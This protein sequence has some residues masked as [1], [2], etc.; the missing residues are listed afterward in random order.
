MR[1][2]V[3]EVR[4]EYGLFRKPYAAMSPVSFPFPPPPAVLGMLGAV[5]GYDKTDSARRL[6]WERVRV[7]VRLLAP[8]ATYR[9]AVNLLE[10]E[11]AG[12]DKD[13]TRFFRKADGRLVRIQIPCEFLRRPAYRI[14][15]AGLPEAAR[16]ELEAL[17][18][19]GRSAYTV[20][21]GLAQCL[22]E[23]RW[24]GAR[25]A[26][27]RA[28]DRFSCPGVVPVAPALS[29]DYGRGRR[30]Q[31]LRVPVAMDPERIVHRYQ[32]VVLAEDGEPLTGHGGAGHIYEVGDETV[33]F[34]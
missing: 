17:L 16:S 28:G 22:A 7:G 31:R 15:V 30:F 26:R 9:G 33:A 25:Q 23:L 27:P 13:P 5:A 1:T 3:F 12:W 2:L 14:Y 18:A 10:T 21:L 32:E 4:G 11:A 6:G 34:L 29:V 20:S 8:V 24:V 19:A